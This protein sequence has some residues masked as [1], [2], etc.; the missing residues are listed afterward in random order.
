LVSLFVLWDVLVSTFVAVIVAAG[1]TAPEASVIEPLISADVACA[2]HRRDISVTNTNKHAVFNTSALLVFVPQGD[3]EFSAPITL[4]RK[5]LNLQLF[6][7][8]SFNI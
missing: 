5:K 7:E 2:S 1:T 4:H 6:I 8:I 3:A